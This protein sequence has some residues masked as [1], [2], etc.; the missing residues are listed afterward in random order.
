MKMKTNK[1]ALVRKKK[2]EIKKHKK[3]N[4]KLSRKF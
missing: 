1:K 3:R 2:N 4:K